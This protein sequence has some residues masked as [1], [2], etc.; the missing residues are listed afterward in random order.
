[1]TPDAADLASD[2]QFW[3]QK[4]S[5]WEQASSKE[6]QQDTCLHLSRFQEFLKQMYEILKEMDS[7]EILERFPKIGQLLAKTC[8]N[9]LILAYDESQKFLVWC[10]CCLMNKEPR[11]PGESELNFW[12]RGLLSH[13]L[14]AFRFDVKEV[15][16]FTESLGYEPVDYWPSL[17]KNMVLSLVSELRESHL[18]GLNTQ[19]RMA[20]ERMM[21]LSQVCV[22]L[23]TLPDF[24]PL[25]EALLTYH[26]HE[27]QEVLSPEF[28]DA[29]NEAFLSKRIILPMCSVVS[30]WFR[31]LPSL[32]KA[33]LHLFEKLLSSKRNCLREMEC[34]VKE[35][36]LPQAACHPAIFRIVD[37]MFRSVLLETDGAPE[38]LAA[39]QIFMSC[40]AEALEKEH[41]Q[42]KFSLKTYF[43]Y[44]APSLTAMLSQR[45]EAIPQRHRLQPLLHISQL[46]REAVEDHT[47]GSQRDPFESWFLLTHF[48][49]WVDLAVEQ[50]LQKEAEPPA[51]LLW[52]LV[53]YYSPQ[54]GS[55]QRAQTVVELKALLNRLLMLLRSD[56]LS[57]ADLQKAAESP[58]ADPRPPICRQLVRRLLLSLLLWTPEGHAVAWEAVT[59]MAHTDAVTHEIV[60]FLDQ[61][62][63]RSDH[64]C[65][66]ASRKLAGELLQGLSSGPARV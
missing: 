61:I 45:P 29:V 6:T 37:E 60:G 8:W 39:L 44:G 11:T 53:F 65:A 62:L 26:G 16:L 43:P 24:E 19:S 12:I 28:F 64:F 32:E 57:A 17:L 34:C 48:G 1:M 30:L 4:L 7:R 20:P 10:L 21:C 35:S 14:S 25:V 42:M 33:V 3:L 63:Y 40:L 41:K 52:L 56:P 51:D 59:H 18:N 38:V 2:C 54:D 36:L 23:I 5:V 27:P 66:E 55:Q 46:L 15:A 49:G 58:S 22:P 13:V 47:H 31:H 9:P 50:L